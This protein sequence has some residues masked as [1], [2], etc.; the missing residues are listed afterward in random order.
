MS[1]ITVW[2]YNYIDYASVKLGILVKHFIYLK[3]FNFLIARNHG[4]LKSVR[5]NNTSS[6]IV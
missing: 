2:S 6:I 4:V 5:E 3:E 1:V